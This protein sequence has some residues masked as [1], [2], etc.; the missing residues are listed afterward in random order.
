MIVLLFADG[1]SR[2]LEDGD[3]RELADR[4]WEMAHGAR[5]AMVA[6]AIQYELKSRRTPQATHHGSRGERRPCDRSARLEVTAVPATAPQ[7]HAG[8]SQAAKPL[9]LELRGVPVSPPATVATQGSEHPRPSPGNSS[10]RQHRRRLDL[11]DLGRALRFGNADDG[12]NSEHGGQSSLGACQAAGVRVLSGHLVSGLTS[13]HR[14]SSGWRLVGLYRRPAPLRPLSW[15]ELPYRGSLFAASSSRTTP[16]RSRGADRSR[17][18]RRS[19]ASTA[20]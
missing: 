4:L 19:R 16:S 11:P 1:S 13:R 8:R 15:F 5:T 3:A 14:S 20:M 10:Y 6:A 2:Q 17:A 12:H 18:C 9:R 7:S